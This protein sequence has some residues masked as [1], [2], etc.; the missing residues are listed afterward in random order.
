MIILR[1]GETKVARQKFYGA[2]KKNSNSK[3]LG[4]M[5]KNG[6]KDK[7]N[8]LV[9]FHIEDEKLLEQ[10]K[11]IWTKIEDLKNIEL[12]VLNRYIKNK[13]RTYDDQHFTNFCGLNML[14]M[15]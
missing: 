15:I 11:T 6:A 5:V 4:F 2:K 3:Y 10:Y 13:M 9:S 1:F 14:K 12:N 8:K 7:S